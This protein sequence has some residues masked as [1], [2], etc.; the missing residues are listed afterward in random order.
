[1]ARDGNGRLIFSHPGDW[2]SNRHSIKV[3]NAANDPL[4]EFGT[5]GSGPGQFINPTGV[6]VWGRRVAIEG[7]YT[8]DADTLLLLHF[9]GS[10]DGAGGEAGDPNGDQL[11]GGPVR[12]GAVG[13]W[14]RHPVATRPPAT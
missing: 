7:P 1:M 12:P 11:R 6:A 9:D 5:E 10:Y 3:A 4:F 8:A 14:R 2:Y 13:G